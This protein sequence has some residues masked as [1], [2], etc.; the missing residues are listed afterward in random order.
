M[1]PRAEGHTGAVNC[2]HVESTSGHLVTGSADS[3]VRVWDVKTGISIAQIIHSGEMTEILGLVE[4]E[5]GKMLSL[6]RSVSLGI[7]V[8]ELVN[9]GVRV[10][11]DI[12]NQQP[13]PSGFG[14]GIW[15]SG[16]QGVILGGY[17]GNLMLL[18]LGTYALTTLIAKLHSW[19]IMGIREIK[20][21]IYATCSEDKSIKIVNVATQ[22]VIHTL[23][24]HSGW[25]TSILPIFSEDKE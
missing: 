12:L 15:V 6:C 19:N 17:N 23:E 22:K 7:K 24:E 14:S 1:H 18:D 21:D 11:K 16:T 13:E 25:V 8:W 10:L 20:Q 9:G 4:V 2:M 3:T 5:K